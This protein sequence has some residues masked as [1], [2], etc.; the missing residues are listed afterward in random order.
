MSAPG[1]WCRLEAQW[2]ATGQL[3]APLV[4]GSCGGLPGKRIDLRMPSPSSHHESIPSPYFPCIGQL[5]ATTLWTTPT[6]CFVTR[7]RFLRLARYVAAFAGVPC[8]GFMGIPMV[9][10]RCDPD[11]LASRARYRS[12]AT[13]ASASWPRT[14][15]G[16]TRTPPPPWTPPGLP[17]WVP[18]VAC[19]VSVA[20]TSQRSRRHS[21]PE[22]VRERAMH[23]AERG[24][25]WA[26]GECDMVR[27]RRPF[28]GH[29]SLLAILTS[30]GAAGLVPELERRD[31]EIS[32]DPRAHARRLTLRWGGNR[33]SDAIRSVGW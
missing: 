11:S 28:I 30:T 16:T 26:G 5:S 19:R 10:R 13:A 7:A 3:W 20:A 4:R 8:C 2:E 33:D 6:R 31:E 1:L 17:A 29:L 9:S 23:W 12:T 18:T 21:P 24:R 25:V 27:M 22:S 32:L 15:T 14:L